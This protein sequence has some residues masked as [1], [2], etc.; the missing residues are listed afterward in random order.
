MWHFIPLAL[1]YKGKQ[2]HQQ[3]DKG[4]DARNQY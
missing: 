4:T 2:Y 1:T 3:K